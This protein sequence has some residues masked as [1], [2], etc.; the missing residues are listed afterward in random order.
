[1]IEFEL[2][3]R[4]FI[5]I[6][7]VVNAVMIINLVK[8]RRHLDKIADDITSIYG[9]C[10]ANNKLLNSEKHANQVRYNGLIDEINGK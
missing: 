4:I 6:L 1:M 2:M 7:L 10:S 5:L 8:I 3:D 9:F